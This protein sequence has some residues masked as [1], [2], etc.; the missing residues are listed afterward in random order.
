MSSAGFY[1]ENLLLY[2]N[3]AQTQG[4]LPL[5]IGE[6]HKFAPVALGVRP[7]LEP[8]CMRRSLTCLNRMSPT[9]PPTCSPA[10]ASMALTISTVAR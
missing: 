4:L 5:P 7:N 8:I 9:L 1:A 6:D 2:S 3:Q 10:R